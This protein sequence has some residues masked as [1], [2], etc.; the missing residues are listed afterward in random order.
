[1]R[2]RSKPLALVPGLQRATHRV[3]LF[4]QAGG[5]GVSQGEAHVLAELAAAGQASVAALHAAFAH[6]RST[7]TS[8]LDRLERRGLLRRALHPE[9]RRSFLIV[10]TPRGRSL[11]RR[12]HAAL[13]ALEAA[14]LRRVRPAELAG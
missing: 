6:R 9:D 14:V 13:A 7:L 2:N 12:V 4:V 8:I 11:A 10:L 5:L 3:G 1:M